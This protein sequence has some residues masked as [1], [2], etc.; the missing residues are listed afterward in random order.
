MAREQSLSEI[1]HLF[2]ERVQF[3]FGK[4][5]PVKRAS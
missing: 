2:L 5:L 3:D 4:V 1:P